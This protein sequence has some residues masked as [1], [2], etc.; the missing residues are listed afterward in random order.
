MWTSS[1][2]PLSAPVRSHWAANWVCERRAM[3][4]VVTIADG[5]T[6]SEMTARSGLIVNMMISTPTT[7]RTEVIAWV[8]VCWSVVAMLSM[9]FV[10]RLSV[11]PRG[12]LSK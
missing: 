5:T 6:R 10:T 9:S 12:W 3:K 2:K 1:T 11:S 4:S 7:V 8:I